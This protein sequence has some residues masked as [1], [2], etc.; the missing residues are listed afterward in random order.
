MS[1]VLDVLCHDDIVK[2]FEGSGTLFDRVNSYYIKAGFT[3]GTL[4]D[5][6]RA[7]LA[8][9]GF[10]D[11]T[12]Y[13]CWNDYLIDQGFDKYDRMQDNMRSWANYVEE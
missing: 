2:K 10:S 8:D 9:A 3:T 1:I 6:E 13:D 12:L 11:G 5:K 4:N 7:F